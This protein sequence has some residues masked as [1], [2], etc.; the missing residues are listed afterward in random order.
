MGISNSTVKEDSS[1]NP[2]S[3]VWRDESDPKDYED[4][5]T[6]RLFNRD[7]P[8]RYPL[9]VLFAKTESDIVD[10]VKLAVQENC[11]ISIRAGGHSFAAWSV[12]DKALLLDLGHHS[13]TVLDEESGVARISPSTTGRDIASYLSSK[14][15]TLSIGHCPDVAIGGFLLGGGMGWNCNV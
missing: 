2:L 12:R 11:R 14:G 7:I 15:R 1:L 5:R 9:A 13:E 10:A 3:V 4:A 6:G 8:K